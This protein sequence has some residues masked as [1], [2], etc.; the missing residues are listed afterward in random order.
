MSIWQLRLLLIMSSIGLSFGLR[1]G[2]VGSEIEQKAFPNQGIWKTLWNCL[3]LILSGG[4][5]AGLSS[6]LIA[7]LSAE[8]SEIDGV[9]GG[10]IFG[11]AGGL[12]SAVPSE[13]I[14]GLGDCIK[15]LS[16]RI[17]LHRHN[18]IPWNYA[19]FLNYS[20]NRLLLQRVGGRYRFMHKLL[21]E[22]FAAMHLEKP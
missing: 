7:G 10:L 2:L 8:I 19:R 15:H 5:I 21:Q 3:V 6:G 9:S 4:L 12:V 14:G 1:S 18:Y 22:H 20:T 13:T 17:V 16:L 11:L